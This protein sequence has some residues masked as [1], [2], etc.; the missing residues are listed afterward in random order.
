MCVGKTSYQYSVDVLLYQV[1]IT[2]SHLL[3]DDLMLRPLIKPELF[4]DI[5]KPTNTHLKRKLGKTGIKRYTSRSKMKMKNDILKH[6]FCDG[7]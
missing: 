3:C 4:S 2:T 5:L 1:T 6:T 7:N